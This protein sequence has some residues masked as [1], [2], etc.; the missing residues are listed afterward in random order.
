MDF[1]CFSTT[2]S[3]CFL[4]LVMG[5]S[6]FS[7]LETDYAFPLKSERDCVCLLYSAKDSVCLFSSSQY[8]PLSPPCLSLCPCPAPCPCLRFSFLSMAICSETFSCKRLWER[9]QNQSKCANSSKCTT[10]VKG[11][12]RSPGLPL[13]AHCCDNRSSLC[14]SLQIRGHWSKSF[15]YRLLKAR[16]LNLQYQVCGGALPVTSIFSLVHNQHQYS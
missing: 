8:Y 4:R 6:C 9:S 11:A 7:Q 14:P 15:R 16:I 1:S 2:G 12:K 10:N 3:S 13:P 5:S